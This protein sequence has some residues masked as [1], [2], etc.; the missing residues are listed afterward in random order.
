MQKGKSF[1]PQDVRITLDSVN[2]VVAGVKGSY[3]YQVEINRE[4]LL[5]TGACT[6]PA[7]DNE[8][9]CKHIAALWL[10]LPPRFFSAS[11]PRK[12]YLF[13][14]DFYDDWEED[15]EEN[16]FRSLPPVRQEGVKEYLSYLDGA[17]RNRQKLVND[18]KSDENKKCFFISLKAGGTGLN[19]TEA[20]YCF[21]LD[22]WW[23]PAVE[24]QAIDRIHRIGQTLPVNAYRLISKDTIEE[25]VLEL[26]AMKAELAKNFMESNEDFIRKLGPQDLNF[27][28]S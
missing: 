22:P 17:S 13:E 20:N 15:D 18:F 3:V 8:G 27:L 2:R 4:N 25:K 12:T 5:I 7:Y 1:F 23:N 14:N 6:C 26:Q 10:N 9:V 11:D 28:F 21:I 16:D 24:N 19:L